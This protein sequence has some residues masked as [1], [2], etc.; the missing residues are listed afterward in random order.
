MTEKDTQVG[1]TVDFQG[2]LHTCHISILAPFEQATF[3]G[4][5]GAFECSMAGGR[6]QLVAGERNG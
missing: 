4:R 5:P 2:I 3:V 6:Q 1:R